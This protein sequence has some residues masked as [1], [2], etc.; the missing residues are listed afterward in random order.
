ML[1][2]G[3]SRRT[4]ALGFGQCRRDRPKPATTGLAGWF[5]RHSYRSPASG[6]TITAERATELG[7]VLLAQRA[8]GDD[9]SRS[10]ANPAT[11]S[12]RWQ[13]SQAAPSEAAAAADELERSGGL[14]SLRLPAHVRGRESALPPAV[15][16]VFCRRRLWRGDRRRFPGV[17]RQPAPPTGDRAGAPQA[18]LTVLRLQSARLRYAADGG[19][20]ESLDDLQQSIEVERFLQI[21]RDL[22]RGDVL[23]LGGA[24]RH[25]HA[26]NGV[27]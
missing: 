10:A 19:G 21:R 12:R 11:R 17:L 7:G 16:S 26:G 6:A 20:H 5:P 15:A 22:G 9:R 1:P 2:V 4:A 18:P 8:R 13:G 23:L 25:E 24:A 3:S 27:A 14:R